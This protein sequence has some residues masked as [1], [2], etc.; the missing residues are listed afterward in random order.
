MSFAKTKEMS[1]QH[2]QLAFNLRNAGIKKKKQKKNLPV[3]IGSLK[4]IWPRNYTAKKE[5]K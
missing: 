1:R 4:I 2:F 3:K 5:K